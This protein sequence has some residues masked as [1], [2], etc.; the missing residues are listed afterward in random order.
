MSSSSSPLWQ[1]TADQLLR[2]ERLLQHSLNGLEQESAHRRQERDR[3]ALELEQMLTPLDALS[4]GLTRLI[5]DM[6]RDRQDNRLQRWQGQLQQLLSPLDQGM[7]LLRELVVQLDH[8]LQPAVNGD[9]QP[10]RASP[11]AQQHQQLALL[12]ALRQKQVLQLQS[13]V[14][15]LQEQL[16]MTASQQPTAPDRPQLTAEEGIATPSIFN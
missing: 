4:D 13:E 14:Q 12:L 2:A 15:T 3:I 16:F 1:H 8:P 7:Q 10:G 6:A 5:D 11:D 9:P